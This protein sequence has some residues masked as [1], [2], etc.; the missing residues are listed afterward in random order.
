MLKTLGCMLLIFFTLAG[1]GSPAYINQASAY[2]KQG[3][4]A[5]ALRTVENSG[6]W[7]GRRYYRVASIY[8]DCYHDQAK[9]IQWATLSARYDDQ[10]ARDYLARVG[11]PIPRPDLYQNGRDSAAA[12]AIVAFGNGFSEATKRPVSCTS[13]AMPSGTVWTDCK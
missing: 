1:C 2:L 5:S 11:A 10:Q 7:A 13:K 4:C 9:T 12:D 3:D 8:S 6:E